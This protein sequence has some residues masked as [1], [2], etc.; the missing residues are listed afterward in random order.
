MCQA[1]QDDE[2]DQPVAG[3]SQTPT[4]SRFG[5]A[6]A[7]PGTSFR[8]SAASTWV[9]AS[10]PES[11]SSSSSDGGFTL[12]SMGSK[13]KILSPMGENEGASEPA[14]SASASVVQLT[15]KRKRTG[16]KE[17]VG[18]AKSNGRVRRRGAATRADNPH[19]SS[20][21]Q[22]ALIAQV[23]KRQKVLEM[24]A[25]RLALREEEEEDQVAKAQQRVEAYARTW[26]VVLSL[27]LCVG[28]PRSVACATT[29]TRTTRS[30]SDS[31]CFTI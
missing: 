15:L 19:E 31:C 22:Q 26:F 27:S 20:N 4:A 23:L 13:G 14:V 5:Q 6:A 12:Q 30:K 16:K 7:G 28:A 9:R 3:P 1:G 24:E 21:A 17:R 18:Q 8:L 11:D 2:S 10:S 25:A 29:T